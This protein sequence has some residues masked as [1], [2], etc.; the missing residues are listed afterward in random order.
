MNLLHNN[1]ILL[2]IK[3]DGKSYKVILK[4]DSFNDKNHPSFVNLFIYRHLLLINLKN[5]R[6]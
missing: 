3:T 4:M 1:G 6:P 2:K 5:G